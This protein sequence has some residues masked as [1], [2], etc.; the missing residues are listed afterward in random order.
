[1]TRFKEIKEN[2]QKIRPDALI[3]AAAASSPNFCQLNPAASR[4]IN[5]EATINLASLCAADLRIPFAFISSDL[6]F[7]G[8][9]PPYSEN[10]PVC[11]VCIYGEQKAEA[12]RAVLERYPRALVCRTA[13]MFGDAGQGAAS[14]I[15]PLISDMKNGRRIN[16][17]VDEYRT[18][19]SAMNA[20]AGDTAFTFQNERD[21]H[22]GSWT[23]FT[24]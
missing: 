2:L 21:I 10:D 9:K 19:V 20:R 16:L 5:V 8:L 13:L 7:D 18:P 12:E 4:A 14:F 11:P 22:F 23:H 3:H 1:M 15:Q 17:F 24:L 6:V